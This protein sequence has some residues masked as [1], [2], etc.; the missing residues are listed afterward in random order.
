MES[1]VER[2]LSTLLFMPSQL[3]MPWLD[4]MAVV[5]RLAQECHLFRMLHQT[6]NAVYASLAS[7]PQLLPT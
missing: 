4:Y 5:I 7:Y 3:V 6:F 1:R 2:S